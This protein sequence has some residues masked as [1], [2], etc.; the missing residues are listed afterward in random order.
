MAQSHSPVTTTICDGNRSCIADVAVLA[1]K[2]PLFP[3]DRECQLAELAAARAACRQR[4]GWAAIFL[5]A[6]GLVVRQTPALRS[7]F[8]PGLR[9]RLATTEQNVATV[10]I[11]RLEEGVER[12][13]WAR[14][15]RP[16]ERPLTDIQQFIDECG[17]KPL[18]EMF[19]RQ[20]ELE[21]LPGWLRRTVL[22][23]N[24]RSASPKRAARLGTFSLSTLAGLGA[25]NRFHPT[26]CTS[27]LAYGPLAAD[28]RCRVTLIADHR[29]VDG[30]LVAR[31][32]MRLEELLQQELV[33]ELR[34]LAD[35]VAD[36]PPSAA[37]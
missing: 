37:A 17:C 2:I 4:I 16:D 34:Q 28:G 8:L 31:S 33:T 36:G 23:W 12:L 14:L 21:M 22:R 9:P 5:K 24:L 18:A 7:W 11:N 26:L 25:D 32:L 13:C 15:D 30:A 19:K 20:L 3:V 6:Y 35:P 27:S 29:V 1:G 10:A